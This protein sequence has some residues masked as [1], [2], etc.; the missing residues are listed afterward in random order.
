M[1]IYTVSEFAEL[2]GVSV[3]TLQRWDREGRLVADRTV[4]NRRVYNDQHLAKALGRTP[5]FEDEREIVGYIRVS[6]RAQKPDL[7]N[8]RT[9][10][11]AFCLEEG[12]NVTTWIEDYGSGLN[13]KRR[14][15]RRL[16]TMIV[17]SRVR[18][19]IVAHKDRL[20]RF[21]FEL[22]QFLCDMNDCELIVVNGDEFSP[23]QE[24]VQDVLTILHVFS[25]RLYGL[26]SYKKKI[27]DAL[28][29]DQS[30]QDPVESNP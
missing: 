24:M 5:R 22:I 16:V 12:H 10:L 13:F 8:Q 1:N 11:E 4:T 26:R 15:L 30:A 7:Q 20:A 18:K 6:T 23:E 17:T 28:K 29:N 25:A 21:G 3:K 19:I 2:V 9:A 27:Q 14:G